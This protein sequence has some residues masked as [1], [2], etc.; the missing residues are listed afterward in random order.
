MNLKNFVELGL[1]REIKDFLDFPSGEI[2]NVGCGNHVVKN[3]ISIDYSDWDADLEELQ[4]ATNSVAGI[5][6]YHFLEHIVDPVRILYEFQRVLK[7]GGVVNIVVPYYNSQMMHHDLDHKH[8]FCEDTWKVLFSNSYYD[9]NKLN[10]KLKVHINFIF[11]LVERNLSLFTQ[12]V[13]YE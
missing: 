5:H 9:K 1:K 8:S 6:C 13:K 3:A 7:V 4:F 11:G 2:L 12:L 10:W